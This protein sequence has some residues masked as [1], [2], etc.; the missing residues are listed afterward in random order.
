MLLVGGATRMPCI[1]RFLKRL[2]G[3][4]V[5][6]VVDPEEAVA[7]GAAVSA[8]ILSGAIDQKVCHLHLLILILAYFGAK[9]YKAPSY[10]GYPYSLW[11]PLLTTKAYNLFSE[12]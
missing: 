5:R 11:L 1:G 6:P 8:G 12:P 2:T 9:A 4:T 7:L 10:Y 3:L